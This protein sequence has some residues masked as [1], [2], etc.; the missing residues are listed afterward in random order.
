MTVITTKLT[1]GLTERK[2]EDFDLCLIKYKSFVQAPQWEIQP[3]SLKDVDATTLDTK[4]ANGFLLYGVERDGTLTWL[5]E[6]ID[7]SD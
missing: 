5:G 7:S 2:R 6:I 1:R 4:L 3:M